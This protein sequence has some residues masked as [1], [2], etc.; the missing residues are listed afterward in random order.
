MN[1]K[2]LSFAAPVIFAALMA[3]AVGSAHASSITYNGNVTNGVYFGTGNVNGG[4]TIATNQGYE[5]ALRA[6][7]YN[8][9]VITPEAGTGVY[10]TWAGEYGSGSHPT[11]PIWNWEFSI[12]NLNSNGTLSGLTASMTI[13][14]TATGFTS[15]PFDLLSIGDNVH[16]R[17]EGAQNSESLVYGFLPGF[18]AL[19][20]DSYVFSVSLNDGNG[21]LVSDSITVNAVPEPGTMAILVAGLVGMF[22]L[23]IVRRRA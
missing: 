18:N 13:L 6:K 7:S 23:Q 12:D 19:V 9:A 10:D 14:N 17:S 1:P 22:G 21:Q 8:G 4:W 20:A 2:Y 11:R 15:A 5:L 16:L 3:S